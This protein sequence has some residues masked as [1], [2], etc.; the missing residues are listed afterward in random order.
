MIGDRYRRNK[1][2]TKFSHLDIK[3]TEVKCWFLLAASS[4]E[5]L[6]RESEKTDDSTREKKE[7]WSRSR[8]KVNS[9]SNIAEYDA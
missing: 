5:N 8:I 4:R 2:K 3:S 1:V 6:K 9:V 7:Q